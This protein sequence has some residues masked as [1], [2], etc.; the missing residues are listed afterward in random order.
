MRRK[1]NDATVNPRGRSGDERAIADTKLEPAGTDNTVSR[2]A[3]NEYECP[4]N[5]NA[6][7]KSR[8]LIGYWADS[9]GDTMMKPKRWADL[10]IRRKAAAHSAFSLQCGL[11]ATCVSEF[12]RCNRL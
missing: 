5:V 3:I 11:I 8:N 7:A 6:S 12:R 10:P 9:F 4:Q 1:S 2:L